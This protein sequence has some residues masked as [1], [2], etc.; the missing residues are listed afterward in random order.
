MK[1]LLFALVLYVDIDA[2]SARQSVAML[3]TDG[4][5]SY[6]V[7]TLKKVDGA[8]MVYKVKPLLFWQRDDYKGS[9]EEATE[10]ESVEEEWNY[11]VYGQHFVDSTAEESFITRLRQLEFVTKAQS[12]TL[13]TPEHDADA[14]NL[15]MKYEADKSK[16]E[17]I[18]LKPAPYANHEDCPVI[19]SNEGDNVLLITLSKYGSE[20]KLMSYSK[21]LLLKVFAPLGVTYVYEGDVDGDVWD[22]LSVVNYGSSKTWCQYVLSE[23]VMNSRED[24]YH[25]F[26][27]MAAVTALQV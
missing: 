15:W 18:P 24:F 2:L 13:N 21:K 22:A 8:T 26:K 25:A 20:K 23:W 17:K 1:V 11:F 16:Y 10:G 12:L 7:S 9:G 3:K 5:P 4:D 27:A 6:V 14:L 19:D